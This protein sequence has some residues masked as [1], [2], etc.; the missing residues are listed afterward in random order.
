MGG[1]GKLKKWNEMKTFNNVAEPTL[2]EVL[3]KDYKLKGKWSSDVFKNDKPIVLELGCGKGE[4][5]VG[6]GEHFP[7]KNFIG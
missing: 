1:K 2:E 6:M 7:E 3:R 5:S 4:Y